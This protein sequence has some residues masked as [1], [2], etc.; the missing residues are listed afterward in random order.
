[1]CV[2]SETQPENYRQIDYSFT[3][4]QIS[5]YPRTCHSR[6]LAEGISGI[7]LVVLDSTIWFLSVFACTGNFKNADRLAGLD[8]FQ[9]SLA[10]SPHGEPLS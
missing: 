10:L 7:V 6:E 9:G 8:D 5:R 1:M 4:E 3:S 2:Q